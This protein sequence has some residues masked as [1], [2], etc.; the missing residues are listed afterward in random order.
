M[1]VETV[2]SRRFNRDPDVRIH[3]GILLE[4]GQIELPSLG[5]RLLNRL[6]RFESRFDCTAARRMILRPPAWVLKGGDRQEQIRD[7]R[8]RSHEIARGNP[9]DGDRN[10]YDEQRL[11]EHG[12]VA[13][14]T[15]LPEVV[16]HQRRVRRRRSPVVLLGQEPS[17]QRTNA[18]HGK[19]VAGDKEAHHRLRRASRSSWSREPDQ[20]AAA[21]RPNW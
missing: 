7:L 10:A 6:V 21:N 1:A 8:S 18:H 15:P 9:D 11:A 4:N 3:V 5:L 2:R 20:A 19:V 14:E 13:A 16:A 17:R 12:T